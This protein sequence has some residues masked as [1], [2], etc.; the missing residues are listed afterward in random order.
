MMSDGTPTVSVIVLNYNGCRWL[1]GCLS[2]L[3]AQDFP[4]LEVILVDNHSSDASIALVK[5]RFPWVRVLA[6]DRNAGF[7]GGNNAGARMAR[8]RFL[9]FLNNDTEA[10]GHWVSALTNALDESPQAGLATS[11]VVYLHDPSIVD[12]AG[13]G[14]ARWGGAFKHRHGQPDSGDRHPVE[15][16]GAC[17]AACM[18]RR[19]VFDQLGG[20]DDDLFLVYED[21]DLS[22]RAQLRD[23]RCLYVPDARVRHAG[24]ATMGTVSRTA[25]FHGQRNLEWVY[26]Q[27][28]PLRLLLRTLPGHVVYAL[29]GGLYLAWSGHFGTWLAAKWAALMGLPS[30]LRKRRVVQRLRSTDVRRL[31][32]VMDR[33][34]LALKWREKRFDLG[35]APSR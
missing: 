4:S 34:W 20:F 6:L 12:S 18:I 15:V 7:S 14:Y 28:T 32:N 24:S 11:L 21:V 17:G 8:G 30:V 29:A 31:W 9:A 1:E 25:V 27:N 5:E 26:F 19:E 10:D 35:K 3:A 2:S 23:H 22:Y 16:F 13:D 33:R